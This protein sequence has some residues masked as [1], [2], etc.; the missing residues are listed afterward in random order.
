M[1]YSSYA[2]ARAKIRDRLRHRG[3]WPSSSS[4]GR[5]KHGKKGRKTEFGRLSKKKESLAERIAASN[6]RRCGQRGHWKWECPQK[7]MAKEDVNLAEDTMFSKYEPEI[8]D[9]LPEDLRV[10]HHRGIVQEH[11]QPGQTGAHCFS[12]RKC[13]QFP[14]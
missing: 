14:C 12:D 8:L 1:Y 6:C 10:G 3:F 4:K 13:F 9:E 5:G 11:D 2:D 7:G